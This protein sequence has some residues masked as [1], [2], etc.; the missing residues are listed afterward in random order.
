MTRRIFSYSFLTGALALLLCAGLIFGLQYRKSLDEANTTL[1]QETA[2]VARGIAL[3]VAGGGT[4]GWVACSL[5][6]LAAGGAYAGITLGLTQVWSVACSVV[7]ATLVV[8]LCHRRK[9]D[10]LH[11]LLLAA[12]VAA[13]LVSADLVSTAQAGTSISEVIESVVQQVLALDTHEVD[14]EVTQILLETR[15]QLLIY[16]PS[17]YAGVGAGLVA[18]SVIGAWGAARAGGAS[19]AG[20]IL[21]FDVPLAVAVLFGLGVVAQLLAQVLPLRADL[22]VMAG[23]NVV[24]CCRIALAQQ[25]LSVILWHLH[26]RRLPGALRIMLV[27]MAAWA[28][29]LIAL[30][31]VVGLL[32][33]GFNLRHLARNRPSLA[34]RSES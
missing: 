3:G 1:R 16:W 21:F 25:G 10:A 11:L 24:M 4:T 13:A 34:Q 12:G 20:V 2:Y 14:V 28:E 9:A 30:M 33:V 26:E 8:W 27:L 29:V 19:L 18:C 23:A 31:S 17:L 32:D 22:L 15:D 5:V 7:C 6:A